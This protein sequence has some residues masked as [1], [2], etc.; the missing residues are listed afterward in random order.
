MESFPPFE[1]YPSD[2]NPKLLTLPN[3][4][5]FNIR[6]LTGNFQS[7]TNFARTCSSLY[8]RLIIEIYRQASKAKSKHANAH[9][10]EACRDGNIR[11][12]ERSLQAE[13]ISHLDIRIQERLN[14]P[15]YTALQFYQVE[16]VEWLL[17]RGADPNYVSDQEVPMPVYF[18]SPLQVAVQCVVTPRLPEWCIPEK[19]YRR[20]LDL[21]AQYGGVLL[22]CI[23]ASSEIGGNRDLV[24]DYID[25]SL[26][27][28]LALAGPALKGMACTLPD[29]LSINRPDNDRESS[30]ASLSTEALSPLVLGGKSKS[31][32]ATCRMA[33][34]TRRVCSS[35]ELAKTAIGMEAPRSAIR[36]IPQW[37]A[38]VSW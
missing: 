6:T 17:A 13:S 16:V 11:T 9:I 15:L 12:L 32:Y 35:L 18:E 34:M 23:A 19:W 37:L 24:N 20:G 22:E 10:Y 14:R 29:P 27:T 1:M 31:A 5:I 28:I 7:K 33:A 2:S 30:I 21:E 4:I 3:E 36:R 38:W 8:D 25:Q 26:T